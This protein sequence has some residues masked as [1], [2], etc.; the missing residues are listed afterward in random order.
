MKLTD[1]WF[2]ATFIHSVAPDGQAFSVG[3]TILNG[4][5]QGL[6]L[7]CPCGFGKPEFPLEGARPHAITIP[8]A[9]RGLPDRFGPWSK[10]IGGRPRWQF[11][12]SSLLDVTVAPSVDVGDPSCWH[13][14]IT[15]G[16]V[17]TC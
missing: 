13:G 7:W 16:E 8:F 14:F 17:K 3:K 11:S 6:H 10:A 15:A 4:D 9:G 2:E 1:P 5:V 12:G